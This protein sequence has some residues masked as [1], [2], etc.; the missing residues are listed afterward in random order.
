MGIL[1]LPTVL[2]VTNNPSIRFWL[3][4][5]LEQEFFIIIASQES[6]ALE[7]VRTAQLDFIVLDAELPDADALSF[8]KRATRILHNL[9]PVILVTP[10]LKKNDREAAKKAGV[11]DFLHVPLDSQE[12]LDRVEG[13]KK[14]L[15]L[16]EKTQEA[17]K[18][19][20]SEMIQTHFSLHGQALSWISNAKKE[21]EP[22]TALV[23]RVDDFA[24]IEKRLGQP[25]VEDLKSPLSKLVSRFITPSD[26]IVSSSD[27]NLVVLLKK[28]KQE[29]V[30][31]LAEKIL[32]ESKESLFDTKSGSISLT[33][34]AAVVSLEG[35]EKDCQN[36]IEAS[37]KA[38][39]K[40]ASN[41][42]IILKKRGSS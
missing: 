8:C 10:N 27:G 42:I 20:S 19:L 2:I 17:A 22:T 30:Q 23:I 24:D 32:K 1:K 12:L 25:A 36:Q 26:L 6:I 37:R 40:I 14:N 3:K 39:Q 16:R 21:D 28:G 33:L 15:A 34:S 41:S 9:I 31:N 18:T 13:V 29:E 35:T 11:T 4:K 38:L 5:R 7:A